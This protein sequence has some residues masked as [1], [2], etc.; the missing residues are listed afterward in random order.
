MTDFIKYFTGLKRNYGFCNINNGY[1]DPQTGK[2]KF[3]SGD[4]GWSGKSITDEDYQQHL[5]GKKSIGIQPCD[6]NGF[7]RFGAIDI[8]PKIYKDL[9]IKFYLDV[10]AEKELPLIPIKS[11]SNGLHFYLNFQLQQKYFQSKLN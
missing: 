3:N 11:K 6:D 1:K 4:Y 7:A 5:D 2:L 10:I 8:D 9:D